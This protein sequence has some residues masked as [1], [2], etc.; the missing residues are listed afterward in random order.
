[1][2]LPPP[3][4]ALSAILSVPVTALTK[5]AHWIVPEA[6]ALSAHIFAEFHKLTTPASDNKS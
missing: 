2:F 4:N 1:M 6:K 5:F 3:Y